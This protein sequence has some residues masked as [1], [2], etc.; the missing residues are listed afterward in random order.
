MWDF[1]FPVAVVQAAFSGTGKSLPLLFQRP[2]PAGESTEVWLHG[3]VLL[4][5]IQTSAGPALAL[6]RCPGGFVQRQSLRWV[7][8][9]PGDRHS[10]IS[11]CSS[12]PALWC[13]LD[14][15]APGC[16]AEGTG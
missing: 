13:H 1:A 2:N 12:V 7:S 8:P 11:S 15:C 9:S 3:G 16:A 10:L 4:Y 5:P 14:V 6:L